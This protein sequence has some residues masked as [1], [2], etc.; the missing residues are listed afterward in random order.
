MGLTP[1]VGRVVAHA[2]GPAGRKRTAEENR[3]NGHRSPKD[4]TPAAGLRRGRK[5]GQPLASH[6]QQTAQ[7]RAER[8]ERAQRRNGLH[9]A[10][11]KAALAQ[12]GRIGDVEGKAHRT[13]AEPHAMRAGMPCGFAFLHAAIPFIFC[14][15]APTAAPRRPQ[16]RGRW[17]GWRAG[18]RRCPRP[19]ECSA[20]CCPGRSC[21]R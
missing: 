2:A 4:A 18:S 9:A 7:R 19:P 5:A 8:D 15:G 16:T 3:R 10:G 21:A 12:A 13:D 6:G 20:R 1:L 17:R 11:Q 14:T